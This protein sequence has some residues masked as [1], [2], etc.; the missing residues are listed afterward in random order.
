VPKPFP[1]EFPRDVIA[2][3]RKAEASI[4]WIPRDFGIQDVPALLSRSRRCCRRC[5]GM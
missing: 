4:A 3:A 5:F 1:A 2:V